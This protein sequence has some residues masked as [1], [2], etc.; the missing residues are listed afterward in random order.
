MTGFTVIQ[1]AKE[2]DR[3]IE[4]GFKS[5]M[6]SG[7]IGKLLGRPAS[8]IRNRMV[9][10]RKNGWQSPA[11]RADSAIT[12]EVEELIMKMSDAGISYRVIADRI[13]RAHSTVSNRITQIRQRRK[14]AES[15]MAAGKRELVR[16]LG[17]CGKMFQS[18]NRCT[19]RICNRCKQRHREYSGGMAENFSV[20]WLST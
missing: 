7:Q 19:N 16:C 10:L 11:G 14:Q 2:E 12:P 6:T 8:T 15:G 9:K 18:E 13:G 20:R 17:G 1:W 3:A 4:E 5:G